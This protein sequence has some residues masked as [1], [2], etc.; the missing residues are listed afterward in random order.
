LSKRISVRIRGSGA[1]VGG[2]RL[3]KEEEPGTM[4]GKRWKEAFFPVVSRFEKASLLRESALQENLTDWTKYL[5]EAVVQTCMSIG[6]Q[7]AAK[8]SKLD[9]LPIQHFEYLSLDV[10]AFNSDPGGKWRYPLAAIELENSQNDERIAYSLWKVLCVRSNLRIVFCYRCLSGQ[11]Q[12]L[13]SYLG[14]EVVRALP[15]E[16]R[17]RLKGETYVVVGSRNDSATFPY[18]FFKWWQLDNNTGNFNVM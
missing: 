7:A 4:T 10:V 3:D 8:G 14:Q 12:S 15:I 16:D 11:G 2:G 17:M 9:T 5:T 18:G 13:I 6:W 1:A